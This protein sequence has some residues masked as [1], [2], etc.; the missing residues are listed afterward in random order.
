MR[1]EK[2]N[3]QCKDCKETFWLWKSDNDP[4]KKFSCMNCKLFNSLKG[5]K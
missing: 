4:Y 1:E 2:L 5:G 3:R